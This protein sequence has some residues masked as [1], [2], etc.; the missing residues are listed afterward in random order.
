MTSELNPQPSQFEF[1]TER[2]ESIP[3]TVRRASVRLVTAESEALLW[4]K[5]NHPDVL[6][7]LDVRVYS[8]HHLVP[9]AVMTAAAAPEAVARQEVEML[10]SDIAWTIVGELFASW[11]ARTKEDQP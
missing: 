11:S 4:I 1:S 10:A 5:Q 2:S 3:A 9:D 8:A 6:D 7:M